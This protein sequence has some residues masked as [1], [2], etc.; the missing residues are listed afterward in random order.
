MEIE[1]VLICG[2]SV[3]Y[4]SQV[5]AIIPKEF[6][7]QIERLNAKRRGFLIVCTIVLCGALGAQGA[8]INVPGDQPT[9]QAGIDAAAD[10]DTVLVA[11]G[12]YTE[13][14]R[15]NGKEAV[16]KSADGSATTIIEP[17]D[18]MVSIVSF[19][20]GEG[21]G[22]VIEGFGLTGTVNAPAVTCNNSSPII[23]TCEIMNCRAQFSA[24]A[25]RSTY[26]SP[27]VMENII[28]TN[29]LEEYAVQIIAPGVDSV[30]IKDNVAHNN[31]GGAV[32]VSNSTVPV[33]VMANVIFDNDGGIAVS[34]SGTGGQ[35]SRNVVFRNLM[36][37]GI[38]L[39]GM[40]GVEVSNNTSYGNDTGIV[41]GWTQGPTL[42]GNNIIANNTSLGLYDVELR[43]THNLV[44]GNGTSF[45]DP[46]HPP[47]NFIAADPVFADPGAGD[48]SLSCE[49]PAID[50]GDP[51]MT[52]PDGSI[53]D[54]GAIPFDHDSALPVAMNLRV[55]SE[56]P[57]KLPPAPPVFVWE[58]VTG[59]TQ[60]AFECEIARVDSMGATVIF[61]SG[62]AVSTTANYA[63]SGPSLDE[64]VSYLV[65]LRL[66]DSSGWGCWRSLAIRRNAAPN[67]AW[68]QLPADGARV[69]EGEVDLQVKPE[70][71][72]EGDLVNYRFEVYADES[73]SQLAGS[74]EVIATSPGNVHSGI[75]GGLAAGSTYW[76]RCTTFDYSDSSAWGSTRSFLVASPGVIYVPGDFA[77]IP[78]AVNYA[79]N[80]DTI[81]IAAGVYEI[82]KG[83]F[84]SGKGICI[85]GSQTGEGTVIRKSDGLA[86]FH[87]SSPS[88]SWTEFKSLR[89]ETRNSISA[90]GD[91]RLRNCVF[92]R[93]FPANAPMVR[94]YDDALIE[95]CR[96][97]ELDSY[98]IALGATLS[99]GESI[100]IVRNEF[101]DASPMEGTPA[102]ALDN[103][104]TL[105][106]SLSISG[107]LIHQEGAVA[108]INL[109]YGPFT[110]TISNNVID[111]AIIGIAIRD[112]SLALRIANNIITNCSQTALLNAALAN[113]NNLWNNNTDYSNTPPGAHD[114]HVDPQ[115][116]DAANGDYRLLCTSPCI[117]AGDPA[118]SATCSGK[119]IDI[120]ALEF[121]YVVG[122]ANGNTS[123]NLINL[124]DA[125]FLVNHIFAGGPAPCPVGAGQV[126]CDEQ[127]TISDVV[128]LVNYLY[129]QGVVP[130]G[131]C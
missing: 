117:D 9:I 52:D 30:V 90:K 97:M 48:F 18:P 75:I 66:R 46:P 43:L 1:R 82:R 51:G 17:L 2:Q 114:L 65:R 20:D 98:A 27:W 36:M 91:L 125:V 50:A 86:V 107:N 95:D 88:N 15:F 94:F 12:V 57:L 16:L 55:D 45:D 79:I 78:G 69:R 74:A 100:T 121:E 11:A 8:T 113:F 25:I 71:D 103:F 34:G 70:S 128:Y 93:L 123:G 60:L 19:I 120:G 68:P 92:R 22:A 4:C 119:R 23:R 109:E 127:L 62:E 56:P 77:D 122:N 104:G 67:K 35:I 63:Y 26:G 6:D 101:I 5:T 58:P 99:G 7:V 42:G 102:I 14:I 124:T 105:A 126:D 3:L 111:K 38:A 32:L 130:C 73:M 37:S 59:G 10:G 76:W 115:F 129:A 96:F 31:V 108:G 44:W 49:S 106:C 80:G 40:D 41:V 61:G 85:R 83:V 116:V 47:N 64:G 89:F 84:V 81:D 72:P 54:M 28:H 53:A 131:G 39:D 29:S 118:S 24:G 87:V 112:T 13:N 21:R 33:Y 110:G